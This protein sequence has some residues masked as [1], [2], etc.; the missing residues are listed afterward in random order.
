M[1]NWHKD[2][3]Q[4]HTKDGIPSKKYFVEMYDFSNKLDGEL[5][6]CKELILIN[7]SDDDMIKKF[8]WSG[9]N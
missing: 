2:M 4:A 6:E 9:E 5:S 8:Q 7:I 1:K 3:L